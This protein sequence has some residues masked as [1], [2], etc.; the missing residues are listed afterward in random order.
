MELISKG[1]SQEN[2]STKNIMAGI[3][4]GMNIVETRIAMCEKHGEFEQQVRGNGKKSR[5]PHCESEAIAEQKQKQ[6]EAMQQH[7]QSKLGKCGIPKRHQACRVNNYNAETEK[8]I[9]LKNAVKAYIE[10]LLSGS[11]KRNFVFLGN[12]GTGKTHLAC[13]IGTAAIHKG[14]T[15]LFSSAS[16]VIRRI[17]AT[18]KSAHETEFELM[19]EYAKLDLLIL[20]EVGVQYQTESA[21]RII[22]EIV[23]DRYNNELPTIFIS[24][25]SVAE[26]AEVMGERAMSRMKQDGCL[27]FV[28]DWADYRSQNQAA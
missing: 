28:C 13:A 11:L 27:P 4:A 8:Q 25:L 20:D 22:T 23:N 3:L 16:E 21:N 10:E 19:N 7:V 6:A 26:F 2:Q 24:N 14:K 17:Q 12:C 1:K 9:A 5:C 18:H 15:V